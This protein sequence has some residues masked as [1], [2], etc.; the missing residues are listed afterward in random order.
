[1]F[2]M[3]ICV[4]LGGVE[5]YGTLSIVLCGPVATAYSSSS[6]NLCFRSWWL[7]GGPDCLIIHL[8]CTQ[9]PHIQCASRMTPQSVISVIV[10]V[11]GLLLVDFECVQRHTEEVYVRERERERKESEPS[12]EERGRHDVNFIILRIHRCRL[13]CTQPASANFPE[14]LQSACATVCVCMCAVCWTTMASPRPARLV[15]FAISCPGHVKDVPG[16]WFR[17]FY[18]VHT[19]T[20]HRCCK[21]YICLGNAISLPIYAIC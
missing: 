17:I 14:C 10:V 21:F 8:D 7:S 3:T 6:L 5:S 15:S 13:S 9:Q 2:G 4:S 18:N 11:A 1:M 16:M 19:C 20:A 12:Q